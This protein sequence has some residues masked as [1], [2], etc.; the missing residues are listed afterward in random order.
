MQTTPS[1]RTVLRQALTGGA[2]VTIGATVVP[3]AGLVRP[4][5]A[6]EAKPL[7]PAELAGFAEAVELAAAAVYSKESGRLTTPAL[8]QAAAAFGDHHRQHA[9]AY[10]PGAA[11]KATGQPNARLVQVVT[12]ELG[13]TRNEQGVAKVFFDMEMALAGTHTYLLGLLK[14]PGALRLAASVL[15]VEA[16][17]ATV[18][19]TAAA[20]P[21]DKIV[22]SFESEDQKLDPALYT[23][24]AEATQ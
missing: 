1:R 7:T 2:V 9:A 15:P 17:H 19:G 18:F 3:V 10:A 5:A 22:P 24:K 13:D 4:A 14:D 23:P 8:Q 6:Q 11:D 21:I 20:Q 12:D 16:Q